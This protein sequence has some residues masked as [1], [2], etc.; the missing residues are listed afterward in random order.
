MFTVSAEQG[1]PEN[2]EKQL[3]FLMDVK[4]YIAY[5]A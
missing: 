3:L 5:A 2:Q 1:A 4:N